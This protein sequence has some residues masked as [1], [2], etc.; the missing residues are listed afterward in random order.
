MKKFWLLL[1]IVVACVSIIT[2]VAVSVKS[3][4]AMNE[5]KQD[6]DAASLLS[7]TIAS[8]GVDNI[9]YAIVYSNRAGHGEGVACITIIGDYEVG[10]KEWVGDAFSSA[11]I[12]GRYFSAYKNLDNV[13]MLVTV[14]A[15]RR[16]DS[17]IIRLCFDKKTCEKAA[18]YSDDQGLDMV[19]TLFDGCVNLDGESNLCGKNFPGGKKRALELFEKYSKAMAT[20]DGFEG[21]KR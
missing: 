4:E 8:E 3:A 18:G 2:A 11:R 1:C 14:I 9:S 15:P 12:L 13:A 20:K 6:I 5:L 16:N 17:P 21:I 10:G 7:A 19:D